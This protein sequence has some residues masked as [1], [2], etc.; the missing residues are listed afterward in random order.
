MDG[1]MKWIL[2]G[3]CVARSGPGALALVSVSRR[4]GGVGA[5]DG[6]KALR[7]GRARA[8]RCSRCLGRGCTHAGGPRRAARG[9][10]GARA[11]SG[12]RARGARPAG[13]ERR[14]GA[15]G[16][17]VLARRGAGRSGRAPMAALREPI[18]V[19]QELESLR[20][21]APDRCRRPREPADAARALQGRRA[22]RRWLRLA[23][24][25][26]RRRARTD[27]ARAHA[28]SAGSGARR[29]R[30]RPAR[31]RRAG[32]PV[33]GEGSDGGWLDD[34]DGRARLTGPDGIAE[35]HARRARVQL[36]SPGRFVALA[37]LAREPVEAPVDLEQP[38][39]E[40][41]E[42]RLPPTG[43]V[44]VRLVDARGELW[45]GTFGACS[46][47][48]SP[49]TACRDRRGGGSHPRAAG[50]DQRRGGASSSTSDSG[51]SSRSGPRR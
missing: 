49:R 39:L 45:R 31:G 1:A 7:G 16:G 41:I 44:A 22:P 25:L 40:P 32:G 19:D 50:Y 24:E 35:L 33:P 12:R 30:G 11:R 9:A 48:L 2:A 26:E 3:A 46:V 20:A 10:R 27:R 5:G 4:R 38:P 34:E 23:H 17:G 21:A 14:A 18:D 42:L 36:R 51:S 29:R 28:G 13:P 43:S 37:I 15:R 47:G 6:W 8:A